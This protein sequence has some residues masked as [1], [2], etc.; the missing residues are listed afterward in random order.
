M[1]TSIITEDSFDEGR[2]GV[3]DVSETGSFI[4]DWILLQRLDTFA[5]TGC[6]CIDRKFYQRQ[7]GVSGTSG[8][9]TQGK[10]LIL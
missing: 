10:Y 5:E 6:F 2:F 7:D 8:T 9:E 1:K 4:R 3:Q